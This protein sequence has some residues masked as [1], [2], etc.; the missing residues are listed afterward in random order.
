[1]RRC[2]GSP[3]PSAIR[4]PT[5]I[6]GSSEPTES[7]KTI[8]MC[9]RICFMR[10]GA[11][12]EEVDA[13]ERDLAR[14]RLDRAAG[15]CGRASILPQPDSPTR[16]SVSPRRTSRSTSVDRLELAATVRWRMPCLT[17]K[18]FFR[19]ADAEQ[20]VV[21]VRRPTSA[22]GSVTHAA[23][24]SSSGSSMPGD[25][26]AATGLAQPAARPLAADVEQRRQLVSQRSKA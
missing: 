12:P 4:S 24:R 19:P 21:A 2:R 5:F 11:E 14:R 3:G 18:Y 15:A 13:V 9:R 23:H 25:P 20:D 17:G 1:M 26:R 22:L 16:P 10:V 6:R 7:W 8:C